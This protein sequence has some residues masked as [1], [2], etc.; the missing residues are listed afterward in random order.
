MTS[1]GQLLK[2]QREQKE[3]VNERSDAADSGDATS[4]DSS[5]AGND[6][7]AESEQVPLLE[8]PAQDAATTAIAG[9]LRLGFGKPKSQPQP[10]GGGESSDPKPQGSLGKLKLPSDSKPGGITN[11]PQ[12][13]GFDSSSGGLAD[14]AADESTEELRSPN[15]GLMPQFDDE[16]PATAPTRELPADLSTEQ[17]QFV[18]LLD[19]IYDVMFDAELFGQMIRSIMQELQENPE[20]KMLI[21]DADVHTMIRGMRE[22]MGLARIKKAEKSTSRRGGS[23]SG[24]KVQSEVM[25]SLENLFG[26]GAFD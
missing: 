17:Q 25:D 2:K 24:P 8:A 22:S 4:P 6:V 5:S 12:P 23:K 13:K 1:L 15:H 11:S 3:S 14:L 26:E 7:Q 19:G 9:K 21:A 18:T 16:I 20:Y 10:A